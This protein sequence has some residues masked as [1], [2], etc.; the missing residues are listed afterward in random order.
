MPRACRSRRR[1]AQKFPAMN[2]P[3]ES[4]AAAYLAKMTPAV[5]GNDGSGAGFAAACRL[6][7]FGLT[8]EQAAPLQA[9]WNETHC[10]PRWTV[11]ELK[12][13]LADAFKRTSAKTKFTTGRSGFPRDTGNRQAPGV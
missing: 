6:V 7:E 5:T 1:H 12:H 8:F 3:V 11:A 9:E 4:S 10:E 13:K 2:T